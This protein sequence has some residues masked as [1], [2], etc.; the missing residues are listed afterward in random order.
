MECYADFFGYLQTEY[1]TL[2]ELLEPSVSVKTK[3]EVAT[4]LVH[5]M[6]KQGLATEFVTELVMNDV[7]KIGMCPLC[8]SVIAIVNLAL[9]DYMIALFCPNVD[10][11]FIILMLSC[12]LVVSLLYELP[13]RLSILISY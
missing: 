4:A 2:C 9:V 8:I 5:I 13:V 6:Q 11:F 12:F 1:Q 3:E 7:Q 10:V